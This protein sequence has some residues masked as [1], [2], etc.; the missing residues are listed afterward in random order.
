MK[1]SLFTTLRRNERAI[2]SGFSPFWNRKFS[3]YFG[4]GQ[5]RIVRVH[6]RVLLLEFLPVIVF[7]FSVGRLH[8]DFLFVVIVSVLNV[9]WIIYM[10]LL[11]WK[12]LIFWWVFNIYRSYLKNLVCSYVKWTVKY[13]L[14]GRSIEYRLVS[15]FIFLLCLNILL[16]NMNLFEIFCSP[17]FTINVTRLW[18]FQMRTLIK[19]IQN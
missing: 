10:G 11:L 1:L 3:V 15:C 7:F 9:T 12:L 2:F 17:L 6:C 13:S 5:V 19:N 4:K 18:N 16:M 14:H 8:I